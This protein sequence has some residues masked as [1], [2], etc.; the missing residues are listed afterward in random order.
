MLRLRP[1]FLLLLAVAIPAA[2]TPKRPDLKKLLAHPQTKPEP[3]I[4]ARAGWDGPEQNSKS[5]VYLQELASSNSAEA[6]RAALVNLLI[7]D[8]RVLISLLATIFVLRSLK[9]TTPDGSEASHQQPPGEI[10][11]A[12]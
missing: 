3:Y 5:I 10:P 7:P 8:W 12:A 1:I 6:N 2:A 9:K 11:R 4:P